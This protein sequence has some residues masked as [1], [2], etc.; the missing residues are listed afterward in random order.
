M[1]HRLRGVLIALSFAAVGGCGLP[2][3]G[4]GPLAVVDADVGVELQAL[5]GRGP[6]TI[7]E[8]CV[9]LLRES[10]GPPVSLIFRAAEVRWD[11]IAKTITFTR[12]GQPSVS[13]RSGDAVVVGGT[14]QQPDPWVQPL[15]DTCP[16]ETFTVHS[17][18]PG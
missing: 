9:T 11:G 7:G 2:G 5:G 8:R 14:G 1:N 13:F 17:I 10:G 15:D 3:Q 12:V 6:I 4:W 16:R 18:E